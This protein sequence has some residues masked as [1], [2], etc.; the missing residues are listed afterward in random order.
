MG[1]VPSDCLD[2]VEVWVAAE[3]VMVEFDIK[4]VFAAAWRH[5]RDIRQRC[6]ASTVIDA[7]VS[8]YGWSND[9][10]ASF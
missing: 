5:V 4:L 2:A 1:Q 7:I 9:Y 6:R 10:G 8:T 3:L